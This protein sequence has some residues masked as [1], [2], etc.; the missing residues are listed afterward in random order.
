V[1]LWLQGFSKLNGVD[2]WQAA[3]NWLEDGS[4]IAP[5]E[6]R[7]SLHM[8][9]GRLYQTQSD[10]QDY[11][12]ALEYFNQA[13]EGDSWIY[14]Y[15]EASTHMFRGEVYR[16][17]KDEFTAEQ[18]LAEFRYALE[19]QPESYWALLNIGHVYLYELM[20]VDQAEIYYQ[21][22]LS[23]NEQIPNVYLYLGDVYRER[24]D[25][26]AA[27]AWYR[28]ALERQPDWQAALDRLASVEE[29]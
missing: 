28:Q 15:D 2:Q 1:N 20:D 3:L 7:S 19:L 10:I 24:G 9:I 11:P 14:P 18:A 29:K 26:A 27:A 22:A 21:Q 25:N 4:V 16:S 23:A 12:L 17:L 6:V 8:R 13:L 5:K